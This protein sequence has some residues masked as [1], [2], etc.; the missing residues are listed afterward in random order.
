MDGDSDEAM[1]G[2]WAARESGSGAAADTAGACA[3]AGAW[4]A[5][6][7]VAEEAQ[8]PGSGAITA[9]VP[10]GNGRAPST[11]ALAALV[12]SLL[13][14]ADQPVSVAD[15]S[16]ALDVAKPKVELALEHLGRVCGDRGVRLQRTNGHVRMVTA[17]ES[18]AAVQ[19]FLGLETT[20]RLSRA[21]LEVLAMVAYRQPTTR[22]E[23]EAIRGVDSDAVLR[24]LVS[25]ELVAEVAR[26]PTVGRPIEYGTTFRF[27]EYFG[28]GSLSELPPLEAFV[29]AAE[30]GEPA[31]GEP[32][33]EP[34]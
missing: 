25:R 23:I 5:R 19:R 30:G 3:D 31:P 8:A 12:E 28:L 21:A 15:L 22:P 14:V 13:F 34:E 18:A 20:G 16:R 10:S 11:T 6:Q 24:T 1:D 33:R 7:A 17:P 26:R 27:L 9:D 29:S 32:V 2:A 4:A